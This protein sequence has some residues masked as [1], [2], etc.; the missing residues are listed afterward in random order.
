MPCKNIVKTLNTTGVLKK[1]VADPAVGSN[2]SR[3][4]SVDVT[5]FRYSD[6]NLH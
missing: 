5:Q 4:A 1:I 6:S 2:H 3:G